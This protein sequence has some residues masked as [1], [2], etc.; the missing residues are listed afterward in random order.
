MNPRNEYN[1]IYNHQVTILK[2]IGI[3]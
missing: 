3:L 1:V 2:Q